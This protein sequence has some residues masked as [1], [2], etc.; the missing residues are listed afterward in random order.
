MPFIG[1]N[2]NLKS[3]G[4]QSDIITSLDIGTSKICVVISSPDENPRSLKILGIGITESEGVKGGVIVN[5]EKAAGAIR[6]AIGQAEQQSGIKIKDVVIGIAGDH[7]ESIQTRCIVA[8][9]NPNEEITTAD[10]E[11]LLED[12]K[13]ISLPMERKII[14]VIPQDYIIDGQD[15]IQD[16]IGMSGVR[17][18]ANV[19]IVTGLAT[20]IQNIHKSAERLNI[21]VRDIVLQ[22]IASSY[23]VLSE[24]EKE[25]G[26]ALI[27][28]GGGTSDIAIYED[29]ILR[30]TS[31]FSVAGKHVTDDIRY[32]LGVILSQAERV[33]KEYGHACLSSISD[34]EVFMIPGI[35]GRKPLELTKSILCQ[36]IEPRMEEIFELAYTEIRKSGFSNR[37]GAGVVLTGGCSLLRGAD[38]LAN[39]VFG[40]PVKIGIPT[41]FIYTGLGPEIENP[42]YSTAVGLALYNI[43]DSVKQ[44]SRKNPIEKQAKT[45]NK[46]NSLFTKMKKFIEEL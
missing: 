25:V 27:D 34:D 43:K 17:M 16:P 26:V 31:T 19:H 33:K 4:F 20:A 28:I 9:T 8:I 18:E 22:P 7:I 23:A 2:E 32:G 35:S 42:I 38:E 5:I 15:G 30:C 29:N 3:S 21:Q 6:K 41:G 12:A 46:K 13:K 10:V 40:M 39:Q 1:T 11:R 37:L 14:H 24:E 44:K 36:I 45:T